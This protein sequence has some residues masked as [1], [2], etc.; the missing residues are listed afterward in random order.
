MSTTSDHIQTQAPSTSFLRSEERPF[1]GAT[2]T[3]FTS[4]KDQIGHVLLIDIAKITAFVSAK[5][6]AEGIR[7][8]YLGGSAMGSQLRVPWDYLGT[9]STSQ[10]IDMVVDSSNL[11]AARNILLNIGWKPVNTLDFF[12]V[13]YIGKDGKEH[14]TSTSA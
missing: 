3:A 8:T 12:A 1:Y 11:D 7:H 13:T 9:R 4:G 2:V 14:T 6:E 5:L 10:I